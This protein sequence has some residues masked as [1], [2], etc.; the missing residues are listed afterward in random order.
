MSNL[1]GAGGWCVA[2]EVGVNCGPPLKM[3]QF[4]FPRHRPAVRGVGLGYVDG[5]LAGR[6]FMS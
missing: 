6:F 4:P 3:G 1:H 5:E 2:R